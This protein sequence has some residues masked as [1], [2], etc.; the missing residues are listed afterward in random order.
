[1]LIKS[2]RARLTL[3]YT[4]LLALSWV[5]LGGVAYGLLSLTLAHEIDGALMSVA[6][7]LSERTQNHA[8]ALIP[9]EVDEAFRRF[10]GFSPWQRYFRML[11][12]MGE[13]DP[14]MPGGDSDRL[15]ISLDALKNAAQGIST[16][17]TITE[18]DREPVRVLTLPVMH[19]SR[20]INFVQVGM[21]LQSVLESRRRFLTIVATT[22][23]AALFLA[24][25]F[26]WLLAKRALQPVDRM[27]EAARRIS[28]EKL[29]QRLHE[30]GSGDELDRLAKTLNAMLDR[31]DV[32]FSQVR[33][34]S[35]NASH[36]LQT[37]LTIIKGELEVTLRA[38]R[39]P[40][41]YQTTLQSVLEETDRLA[42][43]VEGLLLL[44]RTEAGVLRMDRRDVDLAALVEVVCERF[45]ALAR[46]Q[47]IRLSCGQLA[48]LTVAGD[49]E[50]LERLISN[51]VDN[52]LKYTPSE[53]CV[54]VSL[55]RDGEC[56]VL[57]VQ[58]SGI[59]IAEEEQ[60]KIFQPFYRSEN[61]RSLA[62]RGVGLGLSIVRSIAAAH[63]GS[64]SV[65]NASPAGSTFRVKF[66]AHA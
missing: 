54:R 19:G 56:A 51:L 35:S 38:R 39:N 43:L 34:F 36:E 6:K 41:E 10:F 26:G 46:N 23:P 5:L 9:A 8:M 24:G 16:Y 27:V 25:G 22:F 50:R 4:G 58:D 59:G 37:P 14:G 18:P 53:G 64:V 15:P 63:G 65:Q 55:T 29:S 17:E 42:G 33:Q 20:L 61:S 47:G 21:S 44:S 28:A 11:N 1:M 66:P 7:T 40:E 32:A 52:A 57:E 13:R 60:E 3:W 31:L 12:P 62:E 49:P 2:I 45:D 30:T 48:A